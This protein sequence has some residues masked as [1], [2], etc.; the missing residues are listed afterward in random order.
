MYRYERKEIVDKELRFYNSLKDAS[1]KTREEAYKN[2]PENELKFKV[3][4]YTEDTLGNLSEIK[5]IKIAYLLSVL[6]YMMKK[7]RKERFESE[8]R[9]INKVRKPYTQS[10]IIFQKKLQQLFI[11]V[12]KPLI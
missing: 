7:H 10:Q 9:V 6:I 2:N 12:D 8:I 1:P 11:E 4:Q 5:F 3:F